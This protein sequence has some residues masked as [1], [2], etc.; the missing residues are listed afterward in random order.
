MKHTQLKSAL[1]KTGT[2]VMT[3]S[4]AD[5]METLPVTIRQYLPAVLLAAH[6]RGVWDSLT[7]NDAAANRAALKSG[8]EER[9]M[10]VYSILDQK[11]WII[12]EWD[13][14]LTTILFPSDY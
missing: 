11:I 7:P 3:R 13:R 10:S 12:T 8:E 9:I 4:V 5:W 2:V 1:F 6:T 14:S